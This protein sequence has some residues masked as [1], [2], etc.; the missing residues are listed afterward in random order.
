MC[1]QNSG[2]RLTHAA[3][4]KAS[5]IISNYAKAVSLFNSCGWHCSKSCC[6]GGCKTAE[7]AYL[8]GNYLSTKLSKGQKSGGEAM[9]KA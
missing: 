2:L 5:L 8:L 3:V 4:H 1:L 9:A 6:P 7:A